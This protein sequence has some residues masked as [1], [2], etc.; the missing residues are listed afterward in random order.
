MVDLNRILTL[1]EVR[2]LPSIE[3][4]IQDILPRRGLLF[5]AGDPKQGKSRFA[6]DLALQGVQGLPLVGLFATKFARVLFLNSEGGHYGLN[7]R[8]SM[9]EGIP[10]AQLDGIC[11]YPGTKMPFLT[12]ANGAVNNAMVESLVSQFRSFDIVVFDPLVSFHQGADEN[13]AT[14]MQAL[15]IALRT[16]ATEADVGIIIVH[17]TNKPGSK[18]TQAER[19]AAGGNAMRGSSAL[20]GAADGVLMFWRRGDYHSLI[21]P[22]MKNVKGVGKIHMAED[23]ITGRFYR[24]FNMESSSEFVPDVVQWRKE[25]GNDATRLAK[26]FNLAEY[27]AQAALEIE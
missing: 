2:Q 18:T 6:L 15:M 27:K 16:I 17:H 25:F 19:E 21:I 24:G 20:Y 8:E 13:S 5:V 22:E 4:I 23:R 12:L 11:S 9:F 14:H 26:A 1:S 7:A 3:Y 10:K